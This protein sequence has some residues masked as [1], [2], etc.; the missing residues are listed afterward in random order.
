MSGGEVEHSGVLAIVGNQ[1]RAHPIRKACRCQRGLIQPGFPVVVLQVINAQR[2]MQFQQLPMCLGCSIRIAQRGQGFR[3]V[4]I[5]CQD[6][7]PGL[8]WVPEEQRRSV[9][10]GAIGQDVQDLV[11]TVKVILRRTGSKS[12]LEQNPGLSADHQGL[13]DRRNASSGYAA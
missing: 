8:D 4:A 5:I 1:A 6:I 13:Q 10:P 2:S 7:M 12:R 11:S 3:L 9:M